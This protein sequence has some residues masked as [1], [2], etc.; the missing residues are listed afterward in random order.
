MELHQ[1]LFF[2]A[3]DTRALAL[4]PSRNYFALGGMQSIA[5]SLLVC[6]SVCPLAYLKN[7]MSKLHIIFCTG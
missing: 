4:N 1:T 6:L 2:I 3:T 5:V 7:H